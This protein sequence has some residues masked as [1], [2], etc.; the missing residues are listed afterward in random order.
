MT[1]WLIRQSLSFGRLH[2]AFQTMGSGM[3]P[4]CCLA[5]LDIDLHSDPHNGYSQDPIEPLAH[6]KARPDRL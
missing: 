3:A 2:A 4:K 6:G 1:G 5:I